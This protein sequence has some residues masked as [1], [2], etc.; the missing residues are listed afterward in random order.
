MHELKIRNARGE[1]NLFYLD[2]SY[3][4]EIKNLLDMYDL[5]FI[6]EILINIDKELFNIC[7][8]RSAHIIELKAGEETKRIDNVFKVLNQIEDLNHYPINRVLV[9]GGGT[10]Q[11]L[12]G[13]CMGLIKRG[14]KWDF[15]PTTILAQC[16][17]CIGSKTSIN[18]M[19]SKN[20]YGLFYA[21]NNIYIINSIALKQ[22]N[23]DLLSGLGDALH[24]LFLDP[25][26]EYEYINKILKDILRDGISA[27]LSSPNAVLDL[28]YHCHNIKKHYV[29][30]DEFDQEHRKYLNLG[31]SFGHAL[32]Q[33]YE[34][35]IPHGV[36]V[37]HGIYM[38]Y[39][40]NLH[41]FSNIKDAKKSLLD[42]L[43]KTL[44]EVLN[45]ESIFCP[46]MVQKKIGCN[47]VKYLSILKKDKKNVKSSFMLIAL[48]AKT[49]Y[50]KGFSYEELH[51]FL[52]TLS[53]KF[54]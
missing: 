28:S 44:I 29:E 19:S 49:P 51:G 38:A 48:S 2:S 5:L 47:V 18:S 45:Q 43:I 53:S 54:K 22:N 20:L 34:Y 31:H 24:Y 52:T 21:P 26:N 41:C 50:L 27:C 36:A 23:L 32:E 16:D 11:D 33:L 12:A 14:T 9:V 7:K 25:E 30:T 40:L 1:S 3:I 10:I 39:Y 46:K 42:G 35:E 13:T 6:D 37:M 8:S 17:S 4:T 15:I